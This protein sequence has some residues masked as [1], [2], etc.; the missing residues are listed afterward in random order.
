MLRRFFFA[1]LAL[2]IIVSATIAGQQPVQTH[3]QLDVAAIENLLQDQKLPKSIRKQLEHQ[4]ARMQSGS[5]AIKRTTAQQNGSVV[6]KGAVKTA[7]VVPHNTLRPLNTLVGLRVASTSPTKNALD[8]SATG[9]ITVTF[10]QTVIPADFASMIRVYGSTSGYHAG[11]ASTTDNLT[12]TFTPSVA[13]KTGEKVNVTLSSL[14]LPGGY[15]FSYFVHTQITGSGRFVNPATLSSTGSP[16]SVT[17]ADFN[18]D[19]YIDLA[20]ANADGPTGTISVFMNN[21]DGTFAAAVNYTNLDSQPWAITSADFNNDGYMDI[22][23]ATSNDCYLYVFLN[24]GD[25]TFALP[26]SCLIGME[27]GNM[28]AAD[29]DGDG[30]PDLAIPC[31][32]NHTV[33]VFKNNGHGTF[34]TA[35]N[36]YDV[37]NGSEMITA[38]D[39]N[40]DGYIDFAV[41]NQNDGT[42]S[43]LKNNGDGTFTTSATIYEGDSPCGITSADFNGDGYADIAVTDWDLNLVYIYLNDGSGGFSSVVSY[44][45]GSCPDYIE[46]A[47]LNS[48]G[49]IDLVAANYWDG[50]ITTLFGNG[51]GTFTATTS[52]YIEDYPEGLAIADFNGDGVLDLAIVGNGFYVLRGLAAATEPTTPASGLTPTATTAHTAALNWTN[53]DGASRI[54]LATQGGSLSDSPSDG[55]TYTSNS[56]YRSGSNIGSS[57]VVYKGTS[58]SVTVSG[59]SANIQYTFAVFEY[60][61]NGTTTDENYLTSSPAAVT[62]TTS[63]GCSLNYSFS[64]TTGTFTS[65]VGNGGT[66]IGMAGE[67]NATYSNLA[68]GFSFPFAGSSYS[69]IAVCTN[70]WISFNASTASTATTY[71]SGLPAQPFLAPLFDDLGVNSDGDI[72]YRLDG[73]APNRT[74]TVEWN[75]MA[76]T[77]PGGWNNVISFQAILSETGKIQYIYSRNVSSPA[78]VTAFVGMMDALEYY[79]SASDLTT[80]ATV[81]SSTVTQ[82]ISTWPVSGLAFTFTPYPAGNSASFDGGTGYISTLASSTI[83][84]PT[85]VTVEAMIKPNHTGNT[86]EVIRLRGTGADDGCEIQ[87]NDDGS[88]RFDANLPSGGAWPFINSS[89][90]NVFDGSWHHVAGVVD[91]SN[92]PLLYVDGVLQ[93]TG[94]GG[95]TIALSGNGY[96]YIGLHPTNPSHFYYSGLIDELRI[97]NNVRYTSTFTPSTHP[98][99]SDGNTLVLFHFDESSGT[100][101]ADASGNG[102]TGTLYGGVTF[103][104]STAPLPVELTSF[105]A[106]ISNLNAT[107]TWK[108]A[109]EVNNYGF[110]IERRLIDSKASSVNSWGK[111]G[112]VKGSGT[113]NSPKEYSY[114][115]AS[116]ASGT[117]A[118]RLKQIDNNGAFKYSQEAEVTVVVPKVFALSQN[119]PN[120]FNPSTTI[121]FTLAED[122]R[123]SLKVY[124][125]IGREVAMLVNGDM[126]AG[127][128]HSVLF[129]ASKLSSGLYFYRLDAG[130]NSLVR[131][132]VLMK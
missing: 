110:E 114:T 24:N 21:G 38:A 22:A 49:K 93:A 72:Y 18:N 123:V 104:N 2:S 117:Y 64:A 121:T 97:S 79:L 25:G 111:I 42:I 119:Y 103:G 66:S 11:S 31:Y 99:T 48:D 17:A 29:V 90:V 43:V 20:I 53:G 69:S 65:I 116:V 30:F 100:T 60:N 7:S 55:V 112:F 83:A 5:S 73:S 89:G 87:I 75:K 118:Y 132:L 98:F 106:T 23:V 51:D 120:P 115:D 113:S 78:S 63:A 37:G 109:T 91:A 86:Q 59:L 34:G 47:D 33:A 35:V 127:E 52:G 77:V 15:H 130:K 13:F 88:V 95:G 92:V 16:S 82:N 94:S 26:T 27:P 128:L 3:K 74:F 107:L 28:V 67:N 71:S 129:D 39:F 40:N 9:D 6:Q 12:F 36:Y 68:I 125:I 44:G 4:L 76:W 45:T 70:G 50:T 84:V 105:T 19:G 96:V 108:T 1:V 80:S 10:N 102:N 124:D 32:S 14:S 56:C 46:A 126:K 122:S 54:V 41:T 85:A 131:K 101:T 58:N 57:Y 8:Q 62:L 61:G 81:S